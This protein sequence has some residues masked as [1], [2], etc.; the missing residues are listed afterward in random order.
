MVV[1]TQSG[2]TM[3]NRFMAL[4]TIAGLA[5]LAGVSPAVEFSTG[6]ASAA[7]SKA[8]ITVALITSVSGPAAPE[9]SDAPIGFKA[10]IALQ[11]AE[12][13]VNGHKLVALIVDD[14]TT[15]AAL[16]A[17]TA[18]S[19]GAFGIVADSPLFTA[20]AKYPEQAGMPVTGASVDGPEWG[21]QP[22]TNMFASDTGSLDPKYPAN[23]H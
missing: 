7:S 16:A 21:T 10:R 23:L 17:Q 9:F 6:L 14:Q 19:K 5:G 18:I 12:G 13:G 20:A 2:G 4:L 15:N 11:N 8:P 3:K 1:M 22:Y